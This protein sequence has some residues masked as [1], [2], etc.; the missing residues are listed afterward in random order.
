MIIRWILEVGLR[1][2]RVKG[3]VVQSKLW[4]SAILAGCTDTSKPEL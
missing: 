4:V 3:F 1:S 2:D